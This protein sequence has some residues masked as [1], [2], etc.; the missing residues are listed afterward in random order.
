[1]NGQVTCD[2]SNLSTIE[3]WGTVQ[4][5]VQLEIPLVSH[6][7]QDQAAGILP[8]CSLK[9]L[10]SI[11]W[12]RSKITFQLDVVFTLH[13]ADE[14]L[15]RCVL[16]MKSHLIE[17]LN[18]AITIIIIIIVIIIIVIIIIIIIRW[19]AHTLHMKK[20]PNK[21]HWHHSCHFVL[22]QG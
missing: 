17:M 20:T 7:Y 8:E 15:S 10:F 1:M 12:K 4:L 22:F 2:W 13:L 5:S 6:I 19:E 11:W 14:F 16:Q 21:E 3:L 9:W 18:K